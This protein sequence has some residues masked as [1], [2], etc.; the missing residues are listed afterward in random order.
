MEFHWLG[1]RDPKPK[2]VGFHYL[3]HLTHMYGPAV[4][5]KRISSSWR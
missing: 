5:R 1:Q 3:D 2:G 4:R